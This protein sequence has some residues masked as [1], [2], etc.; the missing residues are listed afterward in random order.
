V[1]GE[2]VYIGQYYLVKELGRTGLGD[3]SGKISGE[4]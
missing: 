3:A 2:E 1:K 4:G